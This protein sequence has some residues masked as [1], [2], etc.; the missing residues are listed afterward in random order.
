MSQPEFPLVTSRA[1]FD[2]AVEATAMQ[3][4]ELLQFKLNRP[5]DIHT[6]A[7]FAQSAEE[8]A[9]IKRLVEELG[10]ESDWS[11]PTTYYAEVER[12]L[13]GQTIKRVGVRRPSVDRPERGYGDHT[14]PNFQ[15]LWDEAPDTPDMKRV[16]SGTGRAMLE[17]TDH[18]FPDVRAYILGE[19]TV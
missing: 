1:T 5:V 7:L 6:V 13:A 16:N 9:L 4:V 12:T 17:V 18:D 10:P 11:H 15:E 2:S 14:A 3:V 19:L 8:H